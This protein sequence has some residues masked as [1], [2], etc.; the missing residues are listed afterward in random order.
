MLFY[1]G[2]IPFLGN[3]DKDEMDLRNSE[4]KKKKKEKE[5][6]SSKPQMLS[7]SLRRLL[8]RPPTTTRSLTT[9][10]DHLSHLRNLGVIAH[11][12]AGKTT[13]TERMLFYSGL[14]PFLGNVDDGNTTT[15]YM[16][17]EREKGITIT[18][19]AVTFTW[20]DHVMNLIDTP[21]HID[22][23]VEVERSMR[24]LDGAVGILDGV[25]GVQV[26]SGT[27]A[28]FRN[29][30]D[31]IVFY[32]LFPHTQRINFAIFLCNFIK[33]I[34]RLRRRRFGGRRLGMGSR[35]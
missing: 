1:S 26:R 33:I 35:R 18:S 17:L 16:D 24:V 9:Q 8:F 15:D 10:K 21:G 29:V 2:L 7:H 27:Q 20:R 3:A 12:D 6:N 28:R 14:I 13:V 25:A 32:F 34:I 4:Q 19:A 5:K 22:F 11:I 30:V 23:S 31:I